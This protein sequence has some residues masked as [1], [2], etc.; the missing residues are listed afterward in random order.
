MYR[1]AYTKERE[2]IGLEME[3]YAIIYRNYPIFSVAVIIARSG[4]HMHLKG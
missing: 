1:N 4:A 3:S 2:A